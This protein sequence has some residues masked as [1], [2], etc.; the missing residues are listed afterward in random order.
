VV[1]AARPGRPL[2]SGVVQVFGIDPKGGMELGR[3]PPLFQRLV[4]A[5]GEEAVELLEHVATLVRQ[6]ADQFRRQGRRA[7]SPDCGAPFVVLVVDELADLIAYQPDRKLRERASLALQV[8]ASQG[9]AP[10]V[11]L[12]GEVQDPRKSVVDFR[13]L[14]PVRVALRL[15]EPTQVDMVLGDGVRER[16]ATAHE[17]LESTPGVAWVK[18]DGQRDPDRVRAF[19][20]TDADLDALTAYVTSPVNACPVIAEV[21]Q[22]TPSSGSKGGV[23]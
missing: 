14:F 12:I 8:I 10:G 22:L 13:H 3:A 11:C 4:C 17:I 6:R 5:P 15:D 7:W 19:H 23:A 9:R 2:R 18:V 21:R 20:I 16:G 1:A